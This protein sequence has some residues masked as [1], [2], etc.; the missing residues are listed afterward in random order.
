MGNLGS[1][2]ASPLIS[3]QTPDL[4]MS[5]TCKR[6]RKPHQIL[7]G[8]FRLRK[9]QTRLQQSSPITVP[10]TSYFPARLRKDRPFQAPGES[11]TAEPVSAEDTEAAA[12]RRLASD[13][14][15]SEAQPSWSLGEN[16]WMGAGF[17]AFSQG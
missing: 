1:V 2:I 9:S 4:Q 17:Q 12:T 16:S 10:R 13:C 7:E 15:P 5:A 6:R 3:G 8:N 14:G 11:A